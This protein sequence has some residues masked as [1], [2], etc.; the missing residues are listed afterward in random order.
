M[1]RTSMR[2]II[3]I[4][5]MKLEMSHCHLFNRQVN[6][7]ILDSFWRL[8]GNE[9]AGLLAEQDSHTDGFG[10]R[11]AVGSPYEHWE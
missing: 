4:A 3:L 11:L 2:L 7:N 8:K 6:M 5:S 9:R 1:H 10:F